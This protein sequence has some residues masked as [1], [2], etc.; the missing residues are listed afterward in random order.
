M[1]VAVRRSPMIQPRVLFHRIRGGWAQRGG[2]AEKE[3]AAVEVIP[4]W[5]AVPRAARD[6]PHFATATPTTHVAPA[7]SVLSLLKNVLHDCTTRALH[8]RARAPTA[9]A[10]PV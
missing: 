5:V 8:W 6:E 9:G 10:H 3:D 7:P 1:C 4:R 2:D